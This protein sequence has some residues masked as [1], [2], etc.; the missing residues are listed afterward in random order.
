MRSKSRSKDGGTAWRLVTLVLRDN[1]GM[2][3]MSNPSDAA[4][5]T[6]RRGNGE[7]KGEPFD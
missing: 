6:R 2:A 5:E 1:I 7:K 4:R 3:E